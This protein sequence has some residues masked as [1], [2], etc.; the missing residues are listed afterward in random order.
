MHEP[1]GELAVVREEEGPGRVGIESAY[2]DEAP[3]VADEA[4]YGRASLGIASRRHDAWRLVQ[5]D[6]RQRLGLDGLAV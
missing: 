4:D 6:E 1:V 5:E 2:R 3:C